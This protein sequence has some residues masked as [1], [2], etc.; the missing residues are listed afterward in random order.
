MKNNSLIAP[1]TPKRLKKE[2]KGATRREFGAVQRQ[3]NA[4][5]RAQADRQNRIVP[6]YFSR[7]QADLARIQ[8]Q[9]QNAYNAADQRNLAYHTQAGAQ[10]ASNR[11]AIQQRIAEDVARRGGTMEPSQSVDVGGANAEAAR[12]N[13]RSSMAGALNAQGAHQYAYLGDRQ[14]TAT[15]QGFEQQEMERLRMRSLDEDQRALAKEKGAFKNAKRGELRES[16]RKWYLEKQA[17]N[18]DK[19]PAPTRHVN[20][21]VSKGGK[22]DKT[23]VINKYPD[24]KGKGKKKRGRGP[25]G[26]G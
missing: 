15:Q 11:S 22:N 12:A 16:E 10:D 6:E 17:L 2:I 14:A 21:N 8:G 24:S 5:R 7:Y 19:N 25:K 13:L 18:L 20:V 9:T 3:L 1:I 23:T 4:E 26:R